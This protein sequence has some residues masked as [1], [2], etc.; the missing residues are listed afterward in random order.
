[1]M[2]LKGLPI[3]HKG[4]MKINNKTSLTLNNFASD[5]FYKPLSGKLSTMDK[6]IA[7]I[8]SI[9]IGIL[10]LGLAFI[11]L[12][13]AAAIKIERKKT[14]NTT[15][16]KTKNCATK[17]LPKESDNQAKSTKLNLYPSEIIGTKNQYN[18]GP[19]SA[20]TCH[21]IQAACMLLSKETKDLNGL[22]IDEILTNGAKLFTNCGFKAGNNY[23]ASDIKNHGKI[24]QGYQLLG[25]DD[26]EFVFQEGLSVIQG[27]ISCNTNKNSFVK[28]IE[29]AQAKKPVSL[30][31][32]EGFS[33]TTLIIKS[34]DEIL[35]FD[36]HGDEE[37]NNLAYIRHYDNVDQFAEA[38]IEKSTYAPQIN[39][40]M[41]KQVHK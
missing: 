32:T 27:V 35:R 3:S 30:V 7:T 29:W 1:M 5:F 24:P 26:V 15:D 18:V 9:A 6:V 31:I 23:P 16:D 40:Y 33:T 34:D 17:K 10:T 36:S 14:L 21:A 11:G 19:S 13:L 39:I 20:C 38:F 22:I 8:A 25:K 2:T 12:G 4:N 41:L 28:A 37:S